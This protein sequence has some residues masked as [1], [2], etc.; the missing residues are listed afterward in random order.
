MEPER[1]GCGRCTPGSDGTRRGGSQVL[2]GSAPIIC[3]CHSKFVPNL[4]RLYFYSVSCCSSFP[5]PPHSLSTLYSLGF[6]KMNTESK[7]KHRW[8]ANWRKS[9]DKPS[10][11]PMSSEY[12]PRIAQLLHYC[13]LS[14]ARV[15][16]RPSTCNTIAC[17]CRRDSA[18]YCPHQPHQEARFRNP[19]DQPCMRID[20]HE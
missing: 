6:E 1:G 5:D 9:L 10:L 17:H 8:Q 15:S 12:L 11:W 13:P 7:F 14:P 16:N 20:R 2:R 19:T 3:N 4:R 18:H